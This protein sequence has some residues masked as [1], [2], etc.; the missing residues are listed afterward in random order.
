[1][2][3][4]GELLASGA[5]DWVS[6]REAY[7][8]A[9]DAGVTDP[10]AVRALAVGLIAE[11]LVGGLMVAGDVSESG[12]QAWE[13]TPGDAVARIATDWFS[14]PDPVIGVGEVVWLDITP[15]GEQR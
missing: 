2:D 8:I 5:D 9:A 13:V 6:A 10:A 4:V 12:F 14:R 11:V 3:L 1:M 15:S 7:G